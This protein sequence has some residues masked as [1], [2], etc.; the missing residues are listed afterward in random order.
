RSQPEDWYQVP[1][2]MI[3]D[4]G[5]AVLLSNYGNSLG[6]ALRTLYPEHKWDLTKISDYRSKNGSKKE[7]AAV[8]EWIKYAERGLL[9]KELSD[10]YKVTPHQVIKVQGSSL[11]QKLGGLPPILTR[12]YP[13]FPWNFSR[14]ISPSTKASQPWVA[15]VLRRIYPRGQ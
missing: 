2:Q 3:K 8:R 9:I 7:I 13:D 15:E 1:T 4:E 5:G 12:V 6:R 14:F 10:W 11:V